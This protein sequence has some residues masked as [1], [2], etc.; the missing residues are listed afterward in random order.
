MAEI[1]FEGVACDDCACA[2]AN[3]DTSGLDY[4]GD[5]YRAA[6]EAG[7]AENALGDAAIACDDECD[8]NGRDGFLCDNCGRDVYSYAHKVVSFDPASAAR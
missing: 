5:E 3:G 4:H 8:A 7:V 6:W 2:I 1:Y